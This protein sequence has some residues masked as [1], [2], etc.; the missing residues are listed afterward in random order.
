MYTN[1]NDQKHYKN[2]DQTV[3]EN[4]LLLSLSLHVSHYTCR[5]LLSLK[6]QKNN[7]INT[8]S[9]NMRMSMSLF[10]ILSSKIAFVSSTVIST[11]ISTACKFEFDCIFI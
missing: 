7:A 1:V 2:N 9:T 10:V 6:S 4:D 5:N 8:L 11:V 3:F